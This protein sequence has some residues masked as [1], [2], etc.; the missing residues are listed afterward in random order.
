MKSTN[1]LLSALILLVFDTAARAYMD[2]ESISMALPAILVLIAGV[3]LVVKI[4]WHRILQ[5]FGLRPPEKKEG[6][7]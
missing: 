5:V 1:L 3:L 2:P 7:K 6:P 4:F